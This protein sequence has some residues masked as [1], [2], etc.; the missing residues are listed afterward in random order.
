MVIEKGDWVTFKKGF[1]CSWDVE[2]DISKKYQ[3]FGASGDVWRSE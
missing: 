1:L 2:E 3:Y